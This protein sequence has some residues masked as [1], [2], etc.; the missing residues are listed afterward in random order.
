MQPTNQAALSETLTQKASAEPLAESCIPVQLPSADAQSGAAVH[1]TDEEHDS[2]QATELS[3]TQSSQPAG[4]YDSASQASGIADANTQHHQ[5][6]PEAVSAIVQQH[7]LQ[8][9]IVK[10]ST[11]MTSY[12]GAATTIIHCW[13]FLACTLHDRLRMC[14]TDG[15]QPCLA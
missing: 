4:T 13:H 7:K 10:V 11:T 9:Q 2:C 8:L 6:L 14:S 12:P 3:G 5:H 1:T 15:F